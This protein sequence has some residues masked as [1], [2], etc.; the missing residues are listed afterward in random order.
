MAVQI[1]APLGLILSILL[2][3]GWVT[4]PYFIFSVIFAAPFAFSA[5]KLS[6]ERMRSNRVK[7]DQL[8][9]GLKTR[10]LID[11]DK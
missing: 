6:Q 3:P 1:V 9:A 4:L 11:R 10:D 5:D 8:G 2:A 7:M